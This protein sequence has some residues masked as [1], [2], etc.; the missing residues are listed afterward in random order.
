MDPQSKD[1]MKSCNVNDIHDDSIFTLPTT[2]TAVEMPTIADGQ[3]IKKL[4]VGLKFLEPVIYRPH[5]LKNFLGLGF[6]ASATSIGNSKS[7]NSADDYAATSR[8]MVTVSRH[9]NDIL[10]EAPPHSRFAK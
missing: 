1:N 9:L 2:S 7:M 4:E 8:A 10:G 6:A 5:I 3:L